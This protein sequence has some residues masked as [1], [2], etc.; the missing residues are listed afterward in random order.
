MLGFEKSTRLQFAIIAVGPADRPSRSVTL[1]TAHAPELAI[2][3]SQDFRPA[4]LREIPIQ[5]GTRPTSPD[6]KAIIAIVRSLRPFP[7]PTST[8]PAGY[9]NMEMSRKTPAP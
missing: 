2:A 8:R 9:F 1:Q 6:R 3:P 5:G 7:G 4:E